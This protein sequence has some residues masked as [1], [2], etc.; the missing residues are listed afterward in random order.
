MADSVAT[1]T[2]IMDKEIVVEQ[3]TDPATL[4]VSSTLVPPIPESAAPVTSTA[5]SVATEIERMDKEI[6][7][8]QNT[9]LGT[10]SF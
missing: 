3:N 8:E 4:L 5:D 7:A 10:A 1:E 9:D 6:L 2:E